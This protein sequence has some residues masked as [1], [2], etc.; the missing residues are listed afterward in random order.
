[1]QCE[2]LAKKTVIVTGGSL[3]I[4]REIVR[5]FARNG[6]RVVVADINEE[7]GT[8]V[9]R[10]LSRATQAHLF[11]TT[12]VTDRGSVEGLVARAMETYG[13]IDVLVN[14][15]GIN[16]PRLLVDA[17]EPRGRYEL[18]ENEF[19]RMV[20]VNIKGPFL[21]TQAVARAMIDGNRPGVIVN[22][23][24]ECGLEGSQG[25]SCYA[26]TKGALF[27]LTRSWAKELGRYGIR[28]TGV[29]PAIVE[30]TAIRTEE[31]E[32]ALAYTRNITVEQLRASYEKVSIPL[33]RV[34]KLSE[35]ASLVCFLASDAASYVTGTTYNISG[36]KSRG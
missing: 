7:E 25:Q 13:S 10:E 34:A 1:M 27:A 24:S 22:I 26:G 8:K 11:V 12:D 14:N 18:H 31:Y 36:G 33:G 5:T 16:L 15:A 17:E 4:G 28:V 32:R 30:T 3:G 6:A 2:D 21:C 35:I 29:A 20:A 9:V 19:D 23:C